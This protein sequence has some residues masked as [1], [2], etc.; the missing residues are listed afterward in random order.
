[1][2]KDFIGKRIRLQIGGEP[3]KDEEDVVIGEDVNVHISS[4]EAVKYDTIVGEKIELRIGAD[5]DMT[6]QDIIS[7]INNSGEQNK[8]VIT[9]LCREILAE[10]NNQTRGQKI[11]DLISVGA[12]IATISQFILQLKMAIG[13]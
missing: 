4:E 9:R 13:L 6:I 2:G 12:G 1:M 10:Q 7:T 11:R 5:V 8:E 3:Q